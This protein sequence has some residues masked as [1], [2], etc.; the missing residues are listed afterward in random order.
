MQVGLQGFEHSKEG[1]F[2]QQKIPGQKRVTNK[3]PK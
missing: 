1:N 2:E 3:T